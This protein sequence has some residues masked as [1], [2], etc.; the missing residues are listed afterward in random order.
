VSILDLTLDQIKSPEEIRAFNGFARP[1]LPLLDKRLGRVFW[2]HPTS[3]ADR[4]SELRGFLRNDFYLSPE[5]RIEHHSYFG[6]VDLLA[7]PKVP[8][9]SGVLLAFE[10]K[11]EDFALERSLKQSA[12]Y[13]G[14][15]V[16]WGPHRGKRISACFLYPTTGLGRDH[17]HRAE[18]QEGMFNLIAQWRV[19]RAYIHRSGLYLRFGQEVIWDSRGWHDTVAN[20][21]LLSKRTVCGSRKEVELNRASWRRL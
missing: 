8:E 4:L 10:V 16:V 2:V 19:G 17:D 15:R 9:L 11:G 3:E 20:R 14:G 12:D 6:R 13:V 18:Y 21:M 5:V 7:V 1:P